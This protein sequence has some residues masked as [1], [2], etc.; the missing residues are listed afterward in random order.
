MS[1]PR[2]AET[3]ISWQCQKDGEISDA[4]SLGFGNRSGCLVG[5][6]ISVSTGGNLRFRA[7]GIELEGSPSPVVDSRSIVIRASAGRAAIVLSLSQK[8]KKR[9]A[10]KLEVDIAQEQAGP[11]RTLSTVVVRRSGHLLR[12]GLWRRADWCPVAPGIAGGVTPAAASS[13]MASMKRV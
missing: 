11:C 2:N 8:R 1:S 4:A 6:E 12:P 9:E 7:L 5:L 13:Y 10:G 3:S